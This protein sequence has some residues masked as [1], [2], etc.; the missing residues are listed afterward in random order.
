MHS[1]RRVRGGRFCTR[2][3]ESVT[4]GHVVSKPIRPGNRAAWR[5][6]GRP[7]PIRRLECKSDRLGLGD[8]S[9]KATALSVFERSAMLAAVGNVGIDRRCSAGTVQD[10]N[11]SLLRDSAGGKVPR[12]AALFTTAKGKDPRSAGL[13]TLVRVK[14]PR[15]AGLFTLV[16]VKDPR[17]AGSSLLSE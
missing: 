14:D 7:S 13:F 3:A 5:R 8:S 17:S 10:E 6:R 11:E 2:V 12:S 9:A 15:S 16:R 4:V 1:S